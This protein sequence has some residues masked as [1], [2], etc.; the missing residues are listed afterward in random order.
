MRIIHFVAAL[1]AV[2]T[3]SAC[4][5]L[6]HTNDNRD[7]AQPSGGTAGARTYALSGFTGVSL[8]GHDNVVVTHGD[9][10]AVSASGDAAALDQLILRVR[11]GKL[12]IRRTSE[13]TLV[14]SKVTVRVTMP[15][16]R[17]ASVAGSG[18]L[19]ADQLSGDDARI[20]VAG[21]GDVRIAAVSADALDVSVA[22]SGQV[23]VAGRADSADISVAGSGDVDAPN[24]QLASSSVSVA[25]SGSVQA[26]V[27]G[28]A[29]INIGGS[30]DVT[31]TGGAQCAIRRA[32]SGTANCS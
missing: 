4:N 13:G 26:R 27:T 25:G 11:D 7:A 24:L 15:L 32:G 22:G 23:Y 8:A 16:L 10:F 1:A 5:V 17:S 29:S 14:R 30:G 12:E 2:S 21:S 19:Q 3:L 6:A 20:S 31:L 9:S 28:S 18:N